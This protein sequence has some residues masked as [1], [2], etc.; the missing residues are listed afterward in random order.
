MLIR[1][2][3]EANQSKIKKFGEIAGLLLFILEGVR[4]VR[5]KLPANLCVSLLFLSS[6]TFLYAPVL[7]AALP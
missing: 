5:G 2:I 7:K 4:K 3:E 6:R 1:F